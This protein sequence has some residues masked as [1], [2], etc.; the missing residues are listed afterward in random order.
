MAEGRHAQCPILQRLAEKPS[1][2]QRVTAGKSVW[3]GGV[4]SV[5]SKPSFPCL[6]FGS[7]AS[8]RPSG[9]G[10]MVVFH[11]AEIVRQ[12]GLLAF[13]QQFELDPMDTTYT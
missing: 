2:A 12:R 7:G 10:T 1:H 4:S 6:Q 5:I 13:R 8:I 11:L 3:S 9:G